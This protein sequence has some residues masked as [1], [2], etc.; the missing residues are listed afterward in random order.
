MTI[1]VNFLQIPDIKDGLYGVGRPRAVG[2]ACRI[3]APMPWKVSFLNS[4]IGLGPRKLR[5]SGSQIRGQ[6]KRRASL[7]SVCGWFGATFAYGTASKQP[8]VARSSVLI[9]ITCCLA[10]QPP[11]GMIL[12]T[13]WKRTAGGAGLWAARKPARFAGAAFDY[14]SARAHSI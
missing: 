8:Y 6:D 3:S 11:P 1:Y 9:S 14:R 5:K 12:A 13:T 7:P 10:P 2:E 4:G